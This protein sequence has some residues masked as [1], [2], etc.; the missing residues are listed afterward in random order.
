MSYHPTARVAFIVCSDTTSLLQ[1]HFTQASE[2][3]DPDTLHPFQPV[4]G[5]MYQAF[6][7]VVHAVCTPYTTSPAEIATVCAAV[8]P[9]Y[10]SPILNDWKTA[11]DREEEYEIPLGASGRLASMWRGKIATAVQ[12]LYP[13]NKAAEE[14]ARE[15][16]P[17]VP[18]SLDNPA[19]NRLLTT[20]S[21]GKGEQPY[22]D[23]P[24]MARFL[25]VASY[26]CSYNPTRADVRII[27]KLRE[28]RGQKLRGGGTR[29]AKVG[30]LT[31]VGKLL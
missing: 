21:I 6:A 5:P 22:A 31:K 3:S 27:S 24:R 15:N 7:S 10:I 25:L 30:V 1:T 17:T 8:W 18:L 19:A 9:L 14:W 16:E 12:V 11:N 26:L 28:D 23:L 4:L 2:A 13:R 29:K 20:S